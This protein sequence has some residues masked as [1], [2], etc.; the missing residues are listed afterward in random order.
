MVKTISGHHSYLEVP[1]WSI[2]HPTPF[3]RLEQRLFPPRH[4]QTLEHT[5]SSSFISILRLI[6]VL[7]LVF[8][9]H[10]TAALVSH[11]IYPKATWLEKGYG[12]GKFPTRLPSWGV[13]QTVGVPLVGSLFWALVY[14]T[15]KGMGWREERTVPAMSRR[16]FGRGHEGWCIDA[17]GVTLPPLPT[18][19]APQPVINGHESSSEDSKDGLRKRSTNN[20][21]KK[22]FVERAA[23]ATSPPSADTAPEPLPYDAIKEGIPLEVLRGAIR[24]SAFSVDPVPVPAFW[25]WKSVAS[26]VAHAHVTSVKPGNDLSGIGSGPAISPSERMVL[27]FVGGGYHSGHAP[28]GPLSWTVCRQTSLRVL[29]VNFRKATKDNLAFPAALQDALAAWIYV[30]KRLRFRPENVILMGDSAGGGLALSLQLYLSALDCS[31]KEGEMGLGRAKKLVLHSPMTD[32][33][34]QG[35]SFT[36]NQGVDIISAYM[37]SLARDNYLRHFIP[38]PGRTNPQLV[39]RHESLGRANVDPIAARYDIDPYHLSAEIEEGEH[40]QREL[41]RLAEELPETI[42][43]LGAFHPLFSMGLDARENRYLAQALR[44]L[45]PKEEEEELEVLVTAGSGEIFIDQIRLFTRNLLDL[46]H[47]DQSSSEDGREKANDKVKVS[48]VECVDWHH[49]FAYMNFPGQVKGQV[50]DLVKTFM[51][52]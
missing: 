5:L 30:T 6:Y 9:L 22:A 18:E 35:E 32:L 50:D 33:T 37:C 48:L 10:I 45:R 36:A 42:V 16:L 1:S 39:S 29:G 46:N 2:Y 15:P 20:S 7:L 26:S 40:F 31:R 3:P 13:G 44:L 21:T 4:H 52:A 17:E 27:F 11:A 41:G 8:P 49:V 23:Q 12:R 51:L 43:E 14:G 25:L 34:L 24:G 38:I 47:V 19:T 28:Q